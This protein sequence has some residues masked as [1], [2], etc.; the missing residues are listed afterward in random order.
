MKHL[1][2]IIDSIF[3]RKYGTLHDELLTPIEKVKFTILV[4]IRR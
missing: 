4:L 2:R 1:S 3:N